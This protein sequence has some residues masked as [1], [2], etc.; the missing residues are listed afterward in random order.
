M[1][2]SKGERGSKSANS[3][4]GKKECGDEDPKG[5]DTRSAPPSGNESVKPVREDENKGSRSAR[6]GGREYKGAKIHSAE[7][8]SAPPSLLFF[9]KRKKSDAGLVQ[10]GKKRRRPTSQV[11]PTF[12]KPMSLAYSRKHCLQMLRLYLR[13]MPHW[14][15]HTRLR[16]RERRSLG[17]AE[18]GGW[19]KRVRDVS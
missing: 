19:E 4:P 13:M 14:F 3:R 6:V 10:K 2:E 7:V 17:E 15:A 11:T 12:T 1:G 16:E 5:L 9:D 18:G 8:D